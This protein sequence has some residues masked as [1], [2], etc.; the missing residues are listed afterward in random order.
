MIEQRLVLL[1]SRQSVCAVL[2]MQDGQIPSLL[3]GNLLQL[4]VSDPSEAVVPDSNQFLVVL[5]ALVG[6]HGEALLALDVP[7][8]ALE[9]QVR[10]HVPLAWKVDDVQELLPH[11]LN[12]L[13]NDAHVHMEPIL[14]IQF[15]EAQVAPRELIVF[16]ERN[17]EWVYLD[18]TDG[19]LF[20]EKCPLVLFLKLVRAQVWAVDLFQIFADF[21]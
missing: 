16:D 13:V 1:L 5:P 3:G 6:L 11:V 17:D 19:S 10:T 20:P 21:L 8:W 2:E 12:G 4:D 15:S 14:D 18:F 9:A 7:S